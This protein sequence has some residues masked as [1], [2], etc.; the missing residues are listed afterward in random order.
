[1]RA[2]SPEMW[3]AV[4]CRRLEVEDGVWV[5]GTGDRPG[6]RLFS[7]IEVG[8]GVMDV[9]ARCPGC[10]LEGGWN[11]F[12]FAVRDALGS[13]GTAVAEGGLAKRVSRRLPFVND[14]EPP[15]WDVATSW[16]VSKLCVGS[17]PGPTLLR[18]ARAAACGGGWAEKWLCRRVRGAMAV[19]V[20]APGGGIAA[21]SEVEV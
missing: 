20:V 10:S 6:E 11:D 12:A 2:P 3:C 9:T 21:V 16:R 15:M 5:R 14:G 1:M 7:G 19:A 17:V 13:L 4:D 8:S 18:G